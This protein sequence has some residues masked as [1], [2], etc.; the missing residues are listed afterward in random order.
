VSDGTLSST[1]DLSLTVIAVSN[2]IEAVDDSIGSIVGI[3]QVVT[4]L[5]VFD[6]DTINGSLLTPSQVILSETVADVTGYMTL[7]PDGTVVLA[8]NTPAGTYTLTYQIC[9]LIAP[10]N[11]N[12]GT[13]TVSVLA[14]TMTIDVNSYCSNNV[15]YVSYNVTPDNF[16][17]VGLLTVNW[18]DSSNTIVATATNL[19][20]SGTLLWPGAVVDGSGNGLDWPGWLLVNGEWFQGSDGFELTR[21]SVT[22]VFTVNPTVSLTVNY[23]AATPSCASSPTFV[24]DAQNDSIAA[25]I[26]QATGATG[27]LNVFDNDALNTHLVSG[28]DV[29]LTV[30]TANSH[31]V[32]NADGTV[33]V[34]ANTPAGTYTL[35]YQICENA[36]LTNCSSATVTVLIEMPQ[37]TLVK[38]A[39]LVGSGKIGDT[40]VYTFTVTNTGN[41]TVNDIVINDPLISNTAIPVINTLAPNGV[42]AVTANYT[43]KQ[44]D[45]DLGTI[46]NTAIA[47]GFD[48]N[49]NKV[50]DVSDQG[51]PKDGNDNP[52]VIRLTQLPSI[53]LVK[54]AVFDDNNGDGFAQ[55]GET[56]TYTFAVTNTGSV[57]ITGI[58]INDALTNTVDLSINPSSLAPNTTGT[59]SV[60]YTIT[61][62]DINLGT[63]T[64][65]AV[66]SGYD[67][68]GIKISDVSDDNDQKD[69]VDNPTVLSLNG[70]EIE[71]FTGM[72]PNGDGDNDVFYIRGLECY[73]DNTVEI[74]NRWGVLVFERN[75]Y[76]N[77]D[78]AFKGISEGRVTINQSE[79]LPEGTYFYILR[80]KKNASNGYQKTGYLYINR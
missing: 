24:I 64:N 58:V 33:D 62:A 3:N 51:D 47:S 2:S 7:N 67:T 63:V 34:L 8:P 1:A 23:P 60:S 68:N 16:T 76:N 36:N 72:S 37:I 50:S 69:G 6:N 27:V 49:F 56:I 42:A 79:T 57:T 31:L 5:N 40:I 32:L 25:T 74:Y 28:S 12:T 78:R 59:A 38:T 53:T 13:V 70:C 52:T 4:V 65:S 14:P 39:E 54:T 41:V 26:N 18:V 43:I 35:T 29:T 75:N 55:V 20:L 21:P 80:Y 15:P 48:G 19:P 45:V 44:S 61:Q 30:L 17:A 9:E 66:A 46:T 11:C 73:P 22:M 71:P 10:T 77:T